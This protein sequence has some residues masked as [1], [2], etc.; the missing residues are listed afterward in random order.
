M[1]NQFRL[2]PSKKKLGST[3]LETRTMPSKLGSNWANRIGSICVK[4]RDTARLLKTTVYKSN[5]VFMY[6][7]TQKLPHIY[8]ANH[9]TFPIQIRKIIVQICGNF[10]V[11]Q[12]FQ[13]ECLK[14]NLKPETTASTVDL[15]KCLARSN[16]LI[17]FIRA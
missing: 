4:R 8:T 16:Y 1:K 11:T 15:N 6:W 13:E 17:H 14:M 7:V 3:I 2:L 12:Y 9:T 5:S 10:W